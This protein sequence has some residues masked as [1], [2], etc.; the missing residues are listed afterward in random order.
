MIESF[1]EYFN[2]NENYLKVSHSDQKIS[3]ISFNSITLDGVM[4]QYDITL[5]DIK[6]NPKYNNLSLKSLY[7]KIINLIEKKKIYNKKRK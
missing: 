6:K 7:E 5:D 4:F 2:L 3:L 1:K